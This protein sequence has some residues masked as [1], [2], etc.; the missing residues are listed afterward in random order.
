MSGSLQRTQPSSSEAC[1]WIGSGWELKWERRADWAVLGGGPVFEGGAGGRGGAGRAAKGFSRAGWV[2]PGL[3]RYGEWGGA[4]QRPAGVRGPWPLA[5]ALGRAWGGRDSGGNAGGLVLDWRKGMKEEASV[6]VTA[7]RGHR[8]RTT[9]QREGVWDPGSGAMWAAVLVWPSAGHDGSPRVSWVPRAHRGPGSGDGRAPQ[10]EEQNSCRGSQPPDTQSGGGTP[11]CGLA[12]RGSAEVALSLPALP[13]PASVSLRPHPSVKPLFTVQLQQQLM[14]PGGWVS[15]Q[16]F[17]AALG[18]LA[19]PKIVL[20]ISLSFQT[21]PFHL[22]N[23]QLWPSVSL[24][25]G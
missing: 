2:E 19:W 11:S 10:H 6:T 22:L 18:H 16:P 1:S 23:S 3:C 7:W 4:G 8:S 15:L 17:P 12:S 21:L 20:L 14:V 24:P 25:P 5:A 13:S 9:S